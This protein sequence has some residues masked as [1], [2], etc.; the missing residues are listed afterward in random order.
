MAASPNGAFSGRRAWWWLAA[1]AAALSAWWLTLISGRPGPVGVAI[2]SLPLLLLARGR[3]R[4]PM[5]ASIIS[6]AVIALCFVGMTGSAVAFAPLG[7][8]TILF[9]ARDRRAGRAPPLWHV[10]L[11]AGAFVLTFALLLRV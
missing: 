7:V 9:E 2:L 8:A 4:N 6:G 5:L 11:T 1:F 3:V 10:V